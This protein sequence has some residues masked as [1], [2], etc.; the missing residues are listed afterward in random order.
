[1]KILLFGSNGQ[2]GSELLRTLPPLGEIVAPPRSTVDFAD[3]D[4]LRAVLQT[5]APDIIVNAAAYTAVDRAESDEA[6]AFQVNAAAVEVLARYA[7][8]NG[9]LLVHY[10]TDY[11]FDGNRTAAYRE[12]DATQPLNAYGRTKL[13]GE[14]A[15]QQ[16]GCHALTLRT[17]WVFAAH[18]QN[19]IRTI[20][21]L[22][23][24][25]EQ[26]DVVS[27][28][29]GAPTSAEL[30][31]DVTALAIAAYHADALPEGL[32]HLTASGSTSWYGLACYVV[33]QARAHGA[34]LKLDLPGI[35]AVTSE[36][37]RSAARRPRNSRLDCGKLSEKLGIRLPHWKAH[38]D[39]MLAQIDYGKTA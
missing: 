6:T 1:M 5:Q 28:Q 13:A 26:I 8:F 29:I 9:S 22:A 38:V 30:I 19:F 34:P 23:K 18:G 32:Y 11:V 3:A 7:H 25:R 14:Q 33:Q 24:E 27:D 4:R 21:G 16:G 35:R 36:N 2:I 20:L 17:S 15:V 37:Y 12:L 10:S 39:R 31:A